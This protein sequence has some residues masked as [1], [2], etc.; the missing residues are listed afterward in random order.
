MC[1]CDL[2]KDVLTRSYHINIVSFQSKRPL[3]AN[4]QIFVTTY[5]IPFDLNA[6]PQALELASGH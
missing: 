1:V 6:E 5:K 4:S 3:F 2:H